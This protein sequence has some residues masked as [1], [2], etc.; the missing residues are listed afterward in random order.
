MI[1]T[2]ELVERT[3]KNPTEKCGLST[4]LSRMKALS[5]LV[6]Y[7]I[8][9]FSWTVVP[10]LVITIVNNVVVT[11]LYYFRRHPATVN[12]VFPFSPPSTCRFRVRH[13]HLEFTSART[14]FVVYKSTG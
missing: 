7:S 11:I 9:Y 12:L 10:P 6:I 2:L 13:R 14:E 8:T 5:T 3:G 4:Q 1:D